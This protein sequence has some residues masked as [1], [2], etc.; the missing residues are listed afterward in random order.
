MSF[1]SSNSKHALDVFQFKVFHLFEVLRTLLLRPPLYFYNRCIGLKAYHDRTPNSADEISIEKYLNG[2]I[3][4]VQQV[5][6][7][8]FYCYYYSTTILLTELGSWSST[9]VLAQWP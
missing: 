8:M 4:T 2:V 9:I 1:L 3:W 5:R 7:L 6:G